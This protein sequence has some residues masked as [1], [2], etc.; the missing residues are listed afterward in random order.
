MCVNEE[1]G[2]CDECIGAWHETCGVWGE[3]FL[4]D[5]GDLFDEDEGGCFSCSCR[6]LMFLIGSI[7]AICTCFGACL[8]T[9]FCCLCNFCCYLAK[10]IRERKRERERERETETETERER[11]LSELQIQN[12]ATDDASSPTTHMGLSSHEVS[13]VLMM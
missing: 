7:Y 1:E 12:T 8:Y 10:Q 5:D 13:T 9:L 4:S 2:P 11:T 3:D 6:C